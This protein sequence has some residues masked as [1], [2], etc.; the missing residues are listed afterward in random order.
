MDVSRLRYNEHGL[1]P[2]I[3]QQHDTGDVLMMAWMTASTV[4]ATIATGETVFWSRSR[5]QRWRKG[6]TSGNIQKVVSVTADCDADTVLVR[7]DQRGS[8]ACHTGAPSCFFQDVEND[9]V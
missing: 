6:A 4:R 7:V 8:G 5:G 9:D 3:V 1:I 2:A